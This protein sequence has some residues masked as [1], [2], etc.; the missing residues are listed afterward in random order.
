MSAALVVGLDRLR[1][2]VQKP[3]IIHCGYEARDSGGWHPHG[4]AVDLHIEGLHII[5]QF[6]AAARFDIFTGIGLYPWWNYPGLHLD[7]RPLG[8]N[9]HRAIWGSIKP[10]VYTTVD[11]AFIQRKV[12]TI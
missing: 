3:I 10:K 4:R 8:P 11:R 5:E 12:M 9:S 7:N 6:L 2:F 1:Y